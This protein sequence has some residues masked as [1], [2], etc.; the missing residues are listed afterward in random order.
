[1]VKQQ[2]KNSKITHRL[3]SAVRNAGHRFSPWVCP[4][5]QGVARSPAPSL[6][7][8]MNAFSVS[9]P[10]LKE[11]LVWGCQRKK[12]MGGQVL[13]EQQICTCRLGGLWLA[14]FSFSQ[15]L[16]IEMKSWDV[17]FFKKKLII[18]VHFFACEVFLGA[19][20]D[21][22]NQVLKLFH[23]FNHNCQWTTNFSI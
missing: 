11:L 14:D 8:T 23:F 15:S 3:T 16:A 1:M 21:F 22:P 13:K 5:F 6:A 18:R 10:G 17:S 19:L 12:G 7:V 9:A 20:R 2:G 4:C